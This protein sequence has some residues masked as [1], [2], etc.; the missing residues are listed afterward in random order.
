M[1]PSPTHLRDKKLYLTKLIFKRRRPRR[2]KCPRAQPKATP[3]GACHSFIDTET[4]KCGQI[5]TEKWEESKTLP[6]A[7][8]FWTISSRPSFNLGSSSRVVSLNRALSVNESE[9]GTRVAVA[10][11]RDPRLRA[12]ATPGLRLAWTSLTPGRGA[13]FPSA[14]GEGRAEAAALPL[15]TCSVYAGHSSVAS[16]TGKQ[17]AELTALSVVR[18]RDASEVPFE[19]RGRIP[20]NEMHCTL[21]KPSALR[22]ALRAKGKSKQ[23]KLFV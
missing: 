3:M 2:G 22:S 23:R 11:R 9:R 17:V 7:R 19:A 4:E 13:V 8:C 12:R 6:K 1:P 16:S 14:G 15:V 18:R 10:I 5:N 21:P 20:G